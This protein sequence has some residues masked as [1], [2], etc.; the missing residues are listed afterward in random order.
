MSYMSC[1]VRTPYLHL[2]APETS[3]EITVFGSSLINGE[4]S[5]CRQSFVLERLV[6]EQSLIY[7]NGYHAEGE[8]IYSNLPG[9]ARV[10]M[11][12]FGVGRNMSYRV[13]FNPL[14]KIE[15]TSA[16]NKAA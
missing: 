16:I 1:R 2:A 15:Y 10:E 3:M 14:S 8:V 6:Q 9:L 7:D 4:S 11:D 5:V 13:L 12:R